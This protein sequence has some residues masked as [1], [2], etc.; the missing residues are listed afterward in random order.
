M[1]GGSTQS[2][3]PALDDELSVVYIYDDGIIYGYQ[4]MSGEIMIELKSNN[5]GGFIDNS[6]FLTYGCLSAQPIV[7]KYNLF[8][9]DG[10]N[11]LIFDKMSGKQVLTVENVCD[12]YVG[13]SISWY[14]EY[15]F[16]TCRSRV[17]GFKF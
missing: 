10:T 7:S 13:N 11:V 3:T 6:C 5:N 12:T 8:W 17:V 4:Q 1:N 15:L 9:G 14:H 16:V 2:V